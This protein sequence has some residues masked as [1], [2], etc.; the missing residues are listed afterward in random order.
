MAVLK[1][2]AYQMKLERCPEEAADSVGHM[3]R[4]VANSWLADCGS[5]VIHLGWPH[6]YGQRRAPSATSRTLRMAVIYPAG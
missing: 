4:G 2:A 6:A 5:P 3:Q 1:G